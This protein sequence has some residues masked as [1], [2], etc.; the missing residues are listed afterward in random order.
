MMIRPNSLYLECL[1]S[2]KHLQYHSKGW[3]NGNTASAI[4]QEPRILYGLLD[5]ECLPYQQSVLITVPDVIEDSAHETI[6]GSGY[7]KDSCQNP[8]HFKTGL[9]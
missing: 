3:G 6:P 1:N 7:S 9:L 4:C 8:H 5:E 2:S